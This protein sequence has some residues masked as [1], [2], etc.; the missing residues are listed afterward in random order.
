MSVSDTSNLARL[1]MTLPA[2]LFESL[3]Q[4]IAERGLKSRSSL[5]VELIRG[6]VA[7]HAE[8]S[9]PDDVVA[10]TVTMTY[11]S[12]AGTVRHRIA[13]KQRDY[14]KEV[15]SS[16][17][18]FLENDQSLEVLLV[19]GPPQKLADLCDDLRRVRGVYQV[20]L[21]TTVALLP[22]L[23]DHAGGGAEGAHMDS[24]RQAQ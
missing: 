17:H 4:M 6:A 7:D 8:A 22:Q 16:Q 3:D 15:I 14:L 11:R 21:V 13:Q 19:Q 23:H 12:D 10:G 2:D 20:K 9:R 18:I 5:I 24:E 1:S